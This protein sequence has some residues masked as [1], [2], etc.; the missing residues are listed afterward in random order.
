[1]ANFAV[2]LRNKQ[3]E[4]S[5]LDN[6]EDIVVAQAFGIFLNELTSAERA[7]FDDIVGFYDI[8]G[9]PSVETALQKY[10][11]FFT[12]HRFAYGQYT[13][14][15]KWSSVTPGAQIHSV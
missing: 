11:D 7:L 1:M 9:A 12:D 8:A 15:L 3:S 4:R 5:F 2:L 14:A 6:F 10:T 13:T